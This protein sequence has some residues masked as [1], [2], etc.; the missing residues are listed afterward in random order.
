MKIYLF[1]SIALLLTCHI[2][3]AEGLTPDDLTIMLDELNK[4]EWVDKE[5]HVSVQRHVAEL[6]DKIKDDKTINKIEL[7][8]LKDQINKAREKGHARQ[9]AIRCSPSLLSQILDHANIIRELRSSKNKDK[10]VSF[11]DLEGLQNAE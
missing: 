3:S 6:A 2:Y 11:P 10:H 9:L 7:A 8:A 5:W 1:L 4:N